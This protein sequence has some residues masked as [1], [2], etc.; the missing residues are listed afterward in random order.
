MFHTVIKRKPHDCVPNPQP[1]GDTFEKY[2][3]S[4]DDYLTNKITNKAHK[5]F[6]GQKKKHPDRP[7]LMVL[8]YPAP[9]GYVR[10]CHTVFTLKCS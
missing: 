2:G 1:N 9:H 6:S 4:N 5:F 3:Y 8:N 10:G 7:I